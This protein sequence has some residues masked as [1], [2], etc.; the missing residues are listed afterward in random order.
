MVQR[1][2]KLALGKVA[3]AAEDD[4]IKGLNGNDLAAHELVSQSGLVGGRF[5]LIDLKK[6]VCGAMNLSVMGF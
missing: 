4:V 3:A 5:N 6:P 2:Q 1:G